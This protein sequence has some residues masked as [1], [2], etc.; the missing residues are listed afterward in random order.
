M[1]ATAIA[2]LPSIRRIELQFDTLLPIEAT[3]EFPPTAA[4][5]AGTD[6]VSALALVIQAIAQDSVTGHPTTV[7]ATSVAAEESRSA[8]DSNVCS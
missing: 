6:L 4:D 7:A 8:L 3:A 5:S 1:V 2:A